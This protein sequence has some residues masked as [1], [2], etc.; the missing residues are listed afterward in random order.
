M[1]RGTLKVPESVPEVLYAPFILR[2]QGK[3]LKSVSSD[4]ASTILW[5][6]HR[7]ERETESDGVS[8]SL[9]GQQTNPVI[10]WAECISEA[11]LCRAFRE[12]VHS[13]VQHTVCIPLLS[14][15][16]VFLGCRTAPAGL[17]APLNKSE[18]VS[19]SSTTTKVI[20]I[21]FRPL[22][23]SHHLKD[24]A[25]YAVW[26]RIDAAEAAET[27]ETWLSSLLVLN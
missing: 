4:I 12:H 27:S 18:N 19:V 8:P 5:W 22:N 20:N 11:M 10:F 7:Q 2:K 25:I 16:S 1:M 26:N 17:N 14:L 15:C 13:A 3:F 24:C 6:N 23:F 9:H 21:T